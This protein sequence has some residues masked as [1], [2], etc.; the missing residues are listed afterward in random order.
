[1]A[2][3]ITYNL[4]PEAPNEELCD[5]KTAYRLFG[6][7]NLDDDKL[8]SGTLLPV[9]TPIA[10]DFSTRKVKA[11]KNVKIV[12]AAT[13]TA[14]AYKVQKNSLAYVGMILGN[15]SAGA[16]VSAI[17]KSNASYDVVTV[18]ATLGAAVAVGDV[19]FEASAAGGTTVK[20]KAN[21]LLY[22]RAKV[23]TGATV[24][25]LGAVYSIFESKLTVPVSDKDKITLTSRFMFI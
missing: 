20:N 7:F 1:M 19:L 2:A 24:T 25:A 8:V 12:E 9:L 22:A 21:A 11:C 4:D 16:T 15:G 23:E 10:I 5:F 6:G 13:N 14:T 18:A 17:D 3:G